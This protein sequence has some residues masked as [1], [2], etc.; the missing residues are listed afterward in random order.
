MLVAVMGLVLGA[1]SGEEQA[2]PGPTTSAA[3]ATTT[4]V[5]MTT[6]AAASFCGEAV[7]LLDVSEL[8]ASEPSDFE[9][10]VRELGSIATADLDEDQR[11][12]WAI[13]VDQL[14]SGFEAFTAPDPSLLRAGMWSTEV[15]VNQVN[16]TCGTEVAAYFVAE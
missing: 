14:T 4:T 8:P 9:T 15:V 5:A 13:A 2:E 12:S 16:V 7:A 6:V 1:C 3:P 11:S 10:I